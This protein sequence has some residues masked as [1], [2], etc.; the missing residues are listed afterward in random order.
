[1]RLR[2]GKEKGDQN[3]FPKQQLEGNT[4]KKALYWE[5]SSINEREENAP[6]GGKRRE[7]AKETTLTRST[8]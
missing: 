3:L 6:N 4:K 5:K 2:V 1:L 7:L 8:S